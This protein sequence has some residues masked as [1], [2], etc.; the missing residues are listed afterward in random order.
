MTKK[1]FNFEVRLVAV[2]LLPV[3]GDR[4]CKPEVVGFRPNGSK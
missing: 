1:L 4:K 2:I 3:V